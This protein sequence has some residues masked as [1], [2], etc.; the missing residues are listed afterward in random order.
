[1]VLRDAAI[2]AILYTLHPEYCISQG[3]GL[4]TTIHPHCL[5]HRVGW[6]TMVSTRNHGMAG[7]TSRDPAISC[8]WWDPHHC[9]HSL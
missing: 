4:H 6:N 5:L 8:W 9:M 3:V 7:A 2:A 1:M